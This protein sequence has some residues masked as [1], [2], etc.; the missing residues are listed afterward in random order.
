MSISL[1]WPMQLDY[2]NINH[3]DTHQLS[4]C[5]EEIYSLQYQQKLIGKKLKIINN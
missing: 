1:Q 3:M 2:H 4:L 5:L